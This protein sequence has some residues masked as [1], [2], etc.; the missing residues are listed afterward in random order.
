MPDETISRREHDEFARRIDE[1]NTRQNHRLSLLE[2][3]MTETQTLTVT[4]G[5]LA[6]N[7]ESMLKEMEKQGQRL[8]TLEGRDGEKWR[9]IVSYLIT[10]TLG[11][12]LGAI[13]SSIGF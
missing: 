7:M 4:V 11:I 9:T 2:E 13:F 12:V 5:K 3:R 1:E 6:T 10:A 8:A